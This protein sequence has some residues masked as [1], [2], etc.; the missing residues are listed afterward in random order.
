MENIGGKEQP[1]DNEIA[2]G[3]N[4]LGEK[5]PFCGEVEKNEKSGFESPEDVIA[6]LQKYALKD[7]VVYSRETAEEITDE[8]V[9]L[10]T[11]AAQFLLDR[12]RR[13]RDDAKNNAARL[14]Q[15]QGPEYYLDKVM[16]KLGTRGEENAWGENKMMRGL[17]NDGV[18]E[19]S[20]VK[21][22]DD[23]TD[24]EQLLRESRIGVFLNDENARAY[25]KYMMKENGRELQDVN[26]K[27]DNS[28][29]GSFVFRME[30][31]SEEAK[32]ADSVEE[33]HHPAAKELTRLDQEYQEAQRLGDKER[34]QDILM[35]MR[36]TISENSIKDM[37]IDTGKM[38]TVQKERYL[39]LLKKEI[40]IMNGNGRYKDED[41]QSTWQN[42]G[43]L[44]GEE[45]DALLAEKDDIVK[46]YVFDH[47]MA[48]KLNQIEKELAGAKRDKDQERVNQLLA[49]RREIVYNNRAQ[50]SPEQ[51]G[52]MNAEAKKSY[53]ELKKNEARVLGDKDEY[54]F[55]QANIDKL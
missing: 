26:I 19:A 41:T 39:A 1:Q 44:T 15:D 10:K 51:W 20:L 7:G 5:V 22:K 42:P 30:T 45:I 35:D 34:A 13:D 11:K 40:M 23:T 55:W 18:Y 46:D 49:E 3:Y 54:D 12:A 50:A 2:A 24:P 33:I 9:I 36:K 52:R 8:D 37:K 31:V 25:L 53:F 38:S 43:V 29:S 4:T 17:I 27:Y 16:T 6:E 14:W 21:S 28:K 48:G 47:P 32:S